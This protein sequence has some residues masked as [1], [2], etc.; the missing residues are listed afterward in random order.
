[1]A[2]RRVA[3]ENRILKEILHKNGVTDEYI[4]HCIQSAIHAGPEASP[5]TN[6]AFHPGG[7]QPAASMQSLQQVLAPRRPNSLD[8]STPFLPAQTSRE[9]SIASGSTTASSMWGDSTPSL[10]PGYG[11]HTPVNVPQA[12]LPSSAGH[13]YPGQMYSTEATPR[14]DSFS[15]AQ[16]QPQPPPPQPQQQQQQGHPIMAN[17]RQPG[18]HGQQPLPGNFPGQPMGYTDPNATFNPN[19]RDYGHSGGYS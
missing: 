5:P 9:A 12:T 6:A 16:N 1:M 11:H 15:G 8:P 10:P 17:P 3:E 14:A 18:F 2:A 4:A 13:G 19:P 7:A